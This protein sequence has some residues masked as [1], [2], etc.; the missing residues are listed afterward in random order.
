MGGAPLYLE[1]QMAVDSPV[2]GR[3]VRVCF[4][5]SE[6]RLAI[7]DRGVAVHLAMPLLG[8]PEEE[9]VLEVPAG[10]VESALPGSALLTSDHWMAG[11]FVRPW[12]GA[13]DELSASLY[14]ELLLHARGWNIGRIWNY[15]PEIN[16]E[17]TG[18]ENYRRFNL[19]RWQA[20]HDTF[21]E[22]LT[23]HL[24]AA[25]AVGLRGDMLVT[26]FVAT[27][28][29]VERIENPQQVPA[30]RYPAAYGP[31]AP[32]FVRAART[33]VAGRRWSWISGTASIRGHES[34]AL[35]DV[36]G[37]L[38]VTLENLNVI[39]ATMGLPALGAGGAARPEVFTKVYLRRRSDLGAV[40]DG[41][42]VAAAGAQFVEADVCRSELELEIEVSAR[43]FPH[44]PS[45]H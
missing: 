4:G 41:L 32:S 38:A 22:D 12:H 8:G 9:M 36:P 37:Q 34:V 43:N 1:G 39:L 33:D 31:K 5:R 27:R 40:R 6:T 24:P 10:R 7:D 26:V 44:A 19:G 16:S 28:A 23:S 11:A 3:H 14:R 20:Y 13:L 42:G 25:S 15:V 17:T 35:G 21:G 29:P 45:S 30:W 2:S 18:L